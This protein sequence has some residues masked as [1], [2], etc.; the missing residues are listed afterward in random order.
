[1]GPHAKRCRKLLKDRLPNR[2]LFMGRLPTKPRIHEV[3]MWGSAVCADPGE[4]DL[5]RVAHSSAA[6]DVTC[7]TIESFAP[8]A[9]AASG[10]A[11]SGV[12]GSEVVDTGDHAGEEPAPERR[13]TDESKLQLVEGGNDA[14]A[15][16]VAG[17]ER[18]LRRHYR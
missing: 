2:W 6:M 15:Q 10:Q 11:A 17:E 4:R 8:I 14:V 13:E 12:C 16:K 18:E 5:S 1:M 9:R 3:W 7:P